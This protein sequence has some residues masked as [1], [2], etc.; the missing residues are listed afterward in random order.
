MRK[1]Q[2]KYCLFIGLFLI[3]TGCS[4]QSKKNQLISIQKRRIKSLEAQLQKKSLEVDELKSNR[5]IRESH[6]ENKKKEL[7]SLK[8]LIK[9]KDWIPALKKSQVLKKKYPQS[10]KL[11]YYRYKI[12]KRIG[13]K[14]QA[15]KEKKVI[16]NLRAQRTKKSE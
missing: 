14:E 1:N 12:L 3:F 2:N 16:K 10:V 4:L 13:L 9:K 5:L 8:K 15:L 7:V 6:W 11:R